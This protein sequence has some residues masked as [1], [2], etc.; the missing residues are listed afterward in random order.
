M[1]TGTMVGKHVWDKINAL[2]ASD[3]NQVLSGEAFFSRQGS[4]G[5]AKQSLSTS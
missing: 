3:L 2:V 5:D 4:A 1:S